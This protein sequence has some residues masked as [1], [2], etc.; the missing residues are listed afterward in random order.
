MQCRECGATIAANVSFCP[1]CGA[2]QVLAARSP[3]RRRRQPRSPQP[4]P[5]PRPQPH[6]SPD[7][8]PRRKAR[9]SPAR[10][11]RA[12]HGRPGQAVATAPSKSALPHMGE[13]FANRYRVEKYLGLGACATPTS[14]AISQ[15]A[16]TRRWS[17]RSCMPA[18]P[19]K[20]GMADSFLFLAQSVAKYDHRGI[21]RIFD[22]GTP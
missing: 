14:A 12:R 1:T 3:R 17:S 18:R 19:R 9:R 20:P 21:A 22:A 5:Q 4:L 15:A 16:A 2:R 13:T 6:R 11:A 8:S 7:R 10:P